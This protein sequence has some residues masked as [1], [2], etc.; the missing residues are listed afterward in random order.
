MLVDCNLYNERVE[1]TRCLTCTRK[2][3]ISVRVANKHEG[4]TGHGIGDAFMGLWAIWALKEENPGRE[5]L[6]YTPH[7]DWTK[8]SW[9][10]SRH[11]DD[12]PE[13]SLNMHE[14]YGEKITSFES[15]IDFQARKVGAKN[16]IKPK[17]YFN[18]NHKPVDDKKYI[19]IF[20]FSCWNP[21]EWDVSNYKYLTKILC[22]NG[23]NVVVCCESSK[24][25]IVSGFDHRSIFFH[26][27]SAEFV[28]ALANHAELVICNDSMPA[29]LCGLLD[30]K[31]LAI[32]THL[33]SF[34]LYKYYKNV[35]TITNDECNFCHWQ[36]DRG[37]SYACDSRCWSLQAISPKRVFYEIERR[38][39]FEC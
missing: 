21:R 15:F 8:I 26:G 31:C 30:T 4:A 13:D 5:I 23:Y 28:F 35:H 12:A 10:G 24:A 14:N 7:P 22:D 27:M 11:L 1:K 9:I 29:H 17:L 20:P 25:E 36:V 19:L 33:S 3:I 16:P 39:S 38:I 6:Y 18:R 37:F 2:K 32:H 34:T